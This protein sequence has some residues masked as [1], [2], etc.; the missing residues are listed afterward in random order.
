M[1][2]ENMSHKLNAEID[3]DVIFKQYELL[4]KEAARLSQARGV[5]NGFYSTLFFAIFAVLFKSNADGFY[6]IILSFI[7]MII[8]AVWLV[9]IDEY[10]K[11][12]SAKFEVINSI[13]KNFFKIKPFIQEW[14]ILQNLN[15]NTKGL[16]KYFTLSNVEKMIPFFCGIACFILLI[17]TLISP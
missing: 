14:D 2:S 17:K 5:C 7:M 9:N 15:K 12:N 3:T 13:E 1:Q 16:N 6:T 10:K 4:V 11:L 8:S